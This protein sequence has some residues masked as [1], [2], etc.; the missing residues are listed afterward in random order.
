MS[1]KTEPNV[2]NIINDRLLYQYNDL[3]TYHSPGW[4]EM[5]KGEP[6]FK[7]CNQSF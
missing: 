3:A 4:L 6:I 2:Q 7:F 1:D 5:G